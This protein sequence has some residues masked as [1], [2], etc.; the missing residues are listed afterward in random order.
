MFVCMTMQI[1]IIPD[2]LNTLHYTLN[3][4]YQIIYQKS[5]AQNYS[6]Y[7][8]RHNFDDS[9]WNKATIFFINVAVVDL[10]YCI[11]F[12][13]NCMYA[14]HVKMN[15]HTDDW[16][17]SS[18]QTICKVLVLG[19]QNLGAISGLSTAAI[20]FNNALPK[21]RQVQRRDSQNQKYYIRY[22][23]I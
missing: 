11:F 22:Y 20:S 7:K 6:K 23:I 5:L 4:T 8:G 2:A 21:I 12:F 14:I 13:V 17:P 1:M 18:S 9:K 19:R 16:V 3:V 10:C 15:Y